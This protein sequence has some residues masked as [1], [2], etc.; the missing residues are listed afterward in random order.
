MRT[1]FCGTPEFA[2]EAFRYLID[3]GCTPLAF[4]TQPDKPSGRNQ[5]IKPSPVKQLAIEHS[6]PVL[7]PESLKN[8]ELVEHIRKLEPDLLVVVAFRLIPS[9]LLAIP[10]RG[11]INLH[12]SL[13]P[14]YRGAS[15]IQA[16]LLNDEPVTGVTTFFLNPAID[17]GHIIMQ[18]QVSIT[19][20][21]D[22]GSL[23]D[24]LLNHGKK[25]LYR[26]I[27]ALE[28]WTVTGTPQP[29]GEYH[30]APKFSKEESHI[31]WN[32]PVRRVFNQIRAF[33]PY[34][35]AY[36][37]HQSQA[38]KVLKSE[39]L[40]SHSLGKPGR[41]IHSSEQDGLVIQTQPGTLRIL[42]LQ[43]AGKKPMSTPDYLRGHPIQSGTCWS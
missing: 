41:I 30:Y 36:A 35:G 6:I 19:D 10:R 16:V 31:D 42:N 12:A 27:T 2:A 22:A 8:P 1:L 20:Q 18:N 32:Q 38:I 39:I 37:F 24:K 28:D 43:P 5:S 23:H 3:K 26:T 33:A 4:M 11:A 14:D 29:H 40:E 34:P 25:L 9:S 21:D 13:L 7:Q 15:P 17:A